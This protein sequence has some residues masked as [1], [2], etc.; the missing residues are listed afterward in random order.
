MVMGIAVVA[1][2]SITDLLDMPL[3]ELFDYDRILSK[4]MEGTKEK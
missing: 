3:S 4:I 1:H 2:T